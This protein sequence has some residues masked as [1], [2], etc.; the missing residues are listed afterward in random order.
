MG[1]HTLFLLSPGFFDGEDGPFFCPHSAA[2]E[3]LLQYAPELERVLEIRRVDFKRPR[4]DVVDLLGEENQN[5]PV[6]IIAENQKV[7]AQAQ[8]SAETGRAF[9][10]GEIAISNFLHNAVGTVKPH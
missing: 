6:L 10:L 3:G 1:K 9:I 5:T 8:V 2:L 4:P 7:P